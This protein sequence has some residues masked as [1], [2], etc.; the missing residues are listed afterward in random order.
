MYSLCAFSLICSFSY[1][2]YTV[3]ALQSIHGGIV[4]KP[5]TQ[6]LE[7]FM[8]ASIKSEAKSKDREG[9][10]EYSFKVVGLVT[11]PTQGYALTPD[12]GEWVV[13]LRYSIR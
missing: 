10:G 4:H 5:A 6:A 11:N 2:V 7:E 13:L 1:N 12:G 3:R 9:D 8:S